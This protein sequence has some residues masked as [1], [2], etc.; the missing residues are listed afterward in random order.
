[1]SILNRL[2][3]K[4]NKSRFE[5]TAAQVRATAPVSYRYDD[6]VK[7]VSMVGHSSVDMYLLAAKSFMANLGY[8]S[9]EAI[10]DGSL[11]DADL[12]L[13]KHHIPHITF[14]NAADVNTYDSPDYISWKRLYRA[15]ALAE[16][17]YVIQLDSDTI[18]LSPAIYVNH[19]VKHN[20]GFVIGS[21]KWSVG[22]D[23]E[24][25]RDLCA[26]WQ[27]THVQ[28]L[29]EQSFHKVPFFDG[30]FPYLRGCA[31]FAGY[32]KQFATVDEIRTLSLALEEHV[33]PEWRRWG[34]EQTT[35]LSLISKTPNA[36][37][38]P[39]PTYQNYNFPTV[40]EDCAGATVVHFIG[41]NRFSDN[42]Y[43]RLAKK[44]IKA[45]S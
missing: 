3:H 32:P 45:L 39:W 40:N 36:V 25:M 18:T 34:S 14:F 9:I 15:Q 11:T 30:S 10:N 12:A 7:V 17:A 42:T 6:S 1:M 41:S 33:G 21:D 28:P 23:V 13:I 22:V 4:W 29:A 27:P 26:Q 20:I 24:Y 8:G 38:L 19:C 16:N 44:V 31:G 5:K 2:K 37:M 43:T 35:T